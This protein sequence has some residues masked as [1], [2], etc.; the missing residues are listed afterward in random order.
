MWTWGI[1]ESLKAPQLG[2]KPW[3]IKKIS[4]SFIQLQSD[5]FSKK[6]IDV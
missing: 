6:G 3:Q 2:E 4:K 1:E 5:Y